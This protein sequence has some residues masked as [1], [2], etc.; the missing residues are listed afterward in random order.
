MYE[1]LRKLVRGSSKT[2]AMRLSIAFRMFSQEIR[3][4][5]TSD[6]NRLDA[7]AALFGLLV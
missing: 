2:V 7:S 6:E 3:G 1:T 5:D 4:I